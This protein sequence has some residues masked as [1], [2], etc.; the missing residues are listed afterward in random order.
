MCGV[1]LFFGDTAEQSISAA[2]DRLSHRG[3]DDH[4]SWVSNRIA[5]GFVRL[6]INDVGINGRQPQKTG[7]LIS[8]FN[9]EIYNSD[10][11]VKHYDLTLNS[12]CDAHVIAP[13]FTMLGSQILVELDGFYSGVIYQ[14]ATHTLYL[15]RDHIGKKPLFYGGSNNNLFVVSELKALQSIEWFKQV[16]LGISKLELTTGQLTQVA[17]HAPHVGKTLKLAETM[18]QAIIKRMPKQ[19][20]GIFLSGGLDSS[21]IAKLASKHRQDIIYFVLG[22]SNSSD[23]IIAKKLVRSLKLNKVHYISLPTKQELPTLIAEVVYT[24][25]SYNPSIISNG[26]ATYLLAKAARREGLKVVL[27]G[28]GADELFAGYHEKLSEESWKSIRGKLISDM[29]FTELRR[30]DKCTMAHGIEARCPFLDRAVKSIADN[31]DY[32]EL[33]FED[34]NKAVLRKT[35][36]HLLPIEIANRK[37]M[38]FDVGSGIRKLVV[39]YLTRNGNSE[40]AE[41]KKIWRGI[42]SYNATNTYFSSYPIFDTAIAR[43]GESH[44]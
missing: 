36:G 18:E 30:L 16:P 12:Q 4:E 40:R 43:R 3:P 13:L 9:C 15:M 37:K 33:F 41:L 25:E 27:T 38:S 44:K 24:T 1:A 5:I 34:Y 8:A 31:T 26:L 22:D 6:A 39:N 23:V 17:E 11:L 14:P 32:E 28:E 20:F 10:V 21:I 19:S 35:F 2:L 29:R 7:E 42:F